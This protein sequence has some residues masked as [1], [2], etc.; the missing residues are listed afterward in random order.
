MLQVTATDFKTNFGK[1]LNLAG[2]EEIHITK[3]GVDV[4][5]LVPPR[6]Q[7]SVIDELLGVIPN[8]G[9]TVKQARADY[10]ISRNSK[11]FANSPVPCMEPDAFLSKFF[12]D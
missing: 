8:D 4:A 3:N 1:Y 9:Y 6:P 12:M 2:K 11:D 7:P 10:I 5:I